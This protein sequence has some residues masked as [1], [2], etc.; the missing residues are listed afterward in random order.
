[1]QTA[2]GAERIAQTRALRAHRHRN[3]IVMTRARARELEAV[4]AERIAQ[5][6]SARLAQRRS[7]GTV[8]SKVTAQT[9]EA[10]GATRIAL[11]VH[12]RHSAAMQYANQ[13]KQQIHVLLI[14]VQRAQVC[15]T[16]SAAVTAKHMEMNARQK[17][18]AFQ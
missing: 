18:L 6:H 9:Q 13:V 4:G 3:G 16:R 5:I 15:M 1:M 2:T 10:S 12:V 7:L 8:T 14:A 17:Q 11:L